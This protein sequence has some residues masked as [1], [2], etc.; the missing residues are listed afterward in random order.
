MACVIGW[1]PI[2]PFLAG[3]PIPAGVCEWD[4]MGAYRGEPAEL[5][6]CETVDLEVPASA[7]IVLEGFISDDPATY[8][9]E[10][11]FGE[12]TGY[13]SDVPDAAPDHEGHLHHP[14]ARPDLPRLPGGHAA[15]LL[16]REQRDVVGAAGRHRL[17]HPQG[18]RHPRR[19]RRLRPPDHQR[20]EHRACRSRKH[21]QGQP[22]QI[23]AALWGNSAAQY[24]YKHVYRRG[25]RHR[26]LVLRADRLGARPPG[27]RR[28]G[29]PRR[30]PG[31]LRLA[32]RSQ[33]ADGGPRRQPARHRPLEPRAHRRHALLEVRAPRR[34]GA[35]S[36]S[37]RP[38]ARRPTT[39][40]AC[41]RA[42]PSTAS[43]I[44]SDEDHRG[45]RGP[46]DRSR[47]AR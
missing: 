6:R 11:P 1:D 24:R 16:Q 7:E 3:S 21:Y 31:H 22:K 42:G 28:R 10:G 27:E 37:R 14:P 4:V 23:A 33:H 25:G 36:A 8:E 46:A 18:R 40:R 32:D 29:R 20:R 2:M 12:F 26:R 5:V 17:E 44:C 9:M 30:L 41:A 39:R 34:S 19:P 13:V 43:A 45:P 47:R 35:A 15:R 38:C